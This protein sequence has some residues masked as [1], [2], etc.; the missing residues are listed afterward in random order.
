MGNSIPYADVS[1]LLKP[2]DRNSVGLTIKR[3]YSADNHKLQVSI[4]VFSQTLSKVY[5]FITYSHALTKNDYIYS[6]EYSSCRENEFYR[7]QLDKIAREGMDEFRTKLN[8]FLFCLFDSLKSNGYQVNTAEIGQLVTGTKKSIL[9]SKTSSNIKVIQKKVIT[10]PKVIQT[11]KQENQ[12]NALT[13]EEIVSSFEETF[14]SNSINLLSKDSFSSEEVSL[15]S[16]LKENDSSLVVS[17]SHKD[18]FLIV[19]LAPASLSQPIVIVYATISDNKYTI[20]TKITRLLLLLKEFLSTSY[21]FTTNNLQALLHDFSSVTLHR[22]IN[23]GNGISYSN[24]E[25]ENDFYSLDG[26]NQL[27]SIHITDDINN[28]IVKSEQRF[29]YILFSNGALVRVNSYTP[30]ESDLYTIKSWLEQYGLEIPET[31]FQKYL[32]KANYAMPLF[33]RI[34]D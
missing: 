33:F 5:P 28:C 19:E 20:S 31:A 12:N 22:I 13:R 6:S 26:I 7:K 16:S 25:I 4:E 17:R 30:E 27:E 1:E 18:N 10:I 2:D 24:S 15:L 29:R 23:D 11:I 34:K 9:F 21:K 32:A 3:E 14:S 8:V